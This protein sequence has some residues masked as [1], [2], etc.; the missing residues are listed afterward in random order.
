MAGRL[1]GKAL[2]MAMRKKALQRGTGEGFAA[3]EAY[4]I[5]GKDISRLFAE[6]AR[7]KSLVG[8]EKTEYFKILNQALKNPEDFPE[9][10]LQ[11]QK[12]L[13]I[14]IGMKSGGLAKILEV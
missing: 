13:G 7:D 14:D 3:A 1:V 5:T 8:K 2:G 11:I 4:G 12:K 6:L 10:I 9:E